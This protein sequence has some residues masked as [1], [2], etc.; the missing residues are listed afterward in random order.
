MLILLS[1]LPCLSLIYFWLVFVG[2]KV[3]TTGSNARIASG[4]WDLSVLGGADN[5]ARI[6]EN[7]KAS[8]P[9]ACENGAT[10]FPVVE[11]LILALLTGLAVFFMLI[12]WRSV[13]RK[14]MSE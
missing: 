7:L 5:P 4:I 3:V 13:F 12:H 6:C 11:P 14:D 9:A 8:V 10:F 1:L 2:G